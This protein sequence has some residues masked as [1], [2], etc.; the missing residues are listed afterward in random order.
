[1]RRLI[2]SMA[3]LMAAVLPARAEDC[4]I[5]LH[6][7]ARTDFSLILMEE[8]LEAEG[9]RVVNQDY[10]STRASIEELAR[11][12]ICPPWRAAGRIGCIS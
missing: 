7:L 10:P 11:T 1:M 8:A 2:L 5:L 4:V 6:G 9:Y 3:L 12:T